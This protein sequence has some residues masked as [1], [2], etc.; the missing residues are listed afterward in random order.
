[1]KSIEFDH[2]VIND[3]SGPFVIAEIGVNYYDIARK[4]E[5]AP[6]D[7]AKKMI[8]S[9]ADAGADAVKFQTYKAE[10]LAS[11][12]S[13]AY[14]DTSKERTRSQYELFKKFDSFG[15]DE[16]RELARFSKGQGVIFLSTPF[17]FE[18]VD[19]LEDLMPLFKVSSSDITNT[20]FL[21]YIA[22]K[23][24]PIFLSTG[25]STVGEID[26]AIKTITQEGNNRIVVMHCILNYPTA[27]MDANLGMISHLRN[28]YPDYPVGYSDHTLPDPQMLVL[29]TAV[30][31]GAVVIEK[32]FTLDKT[33]PG[34][35]HY[36]AM[37]SDDLRLF[38]KNLKFIGEILGETE[39]RPLESE[40]PARLYA[41]RSIVAKREIPKGTVITE[42]MI[43][44]KRPGTGLSPQEVR[45]I[46][47]K[48]V[49]RDILEDEIIDKNC[50]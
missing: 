33:L 37:D 42:D 38:I 25:A 27:Y 2:Y 26:E 19:M 44:F 50:F 43:T 31:L 29:T 45:Q 21:Q 39:K 3:R 40:M 18:A 32:H 7:A 9:A 12:Y 28:V 15:E 11:R 36:H 30:I 5:L 16:Y 1:V 22:R 34:N 24:K 20:P 4:E 23:Q 14:W 47:G 49:E 48:R 13:P 8:V 17:D 10:K 6:L 41:R 35:D 46:I